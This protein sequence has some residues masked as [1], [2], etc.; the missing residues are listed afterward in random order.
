MNIFFTGGQRSDGKIEVP[1]SGIRLG[2]ELDNDIVIEGEG[3]S[4]HH[5]RIL[6][7]VEAWVVEDLGSTNGTKLN[8]IKLEPNKPTPIKDGDSIAIGRQIMVFAEKEPA[9]APPQASN[10]GSANP[11][12]TSD[13]NPQNDNKTDESTQSPP[14]PLI[15]ITPPDPSGVTVP[16]MAP[17]DS[18][19]KSE[20]ESSNSFSD[21]FSQQPE[22]KNDASLPVDD[23]FGKTK[24]DMPSEDKTDKKHVGLLFYVLVLGTA[25]L[26]VAGYLYIERMKERK[27]A[28][29]PGASQAAATKK[30]APLLVRYEKEI[31]T[32]GDSENIF[33]FVLEI[34][35]GNVTIVR[36]DLRAHLKDK[37]ARKVGKEDI[38]E[39]ENT[40]RDTDFMSLEQPQKGVPTAEEDRSQR[41]IVAYG[42]DM[43]DI[44][45]D[46]APPPMAFQEV[47]SSLEDF[48]RDVL[49]IPP[50]SLTPEEM[51]QEGLNAYRKAKEL[52]DNYEAK[53]ENLNEAIRRF[54]I[55]VENLKAFS[56]TPP[57]YE[58]AYK[59]L[60]QAEKML[61]DL[62][63]QHF[64]NMNRYY[65][66][67][68]Y[69]KAKDEMLAVMGE[70]G[71]GTDAYK[72]A[73]KTLIKLEQD[74]RKK[75][76]S[77]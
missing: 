51:R 26:M 45:V 10:I 21:F 66:L 19:A 20:S 73:K 62:V 30:G 34:K 58:E 72:K 61:K 35:N 48:S 60:Q 5:A 14:T 31:A 46:N 44:M 43:N 7:V 18:S 24:Q 52:F 57:E 1:D 59:L 23:F 75:R 63:N 4:R 33:R 22:K 27:Y 50:V 15:K 16:D 67:K 36:D 17:L 47:V 11:D 2:R 37:L 71:R 54:K 64:I 6:K 32:S 65:R 69:E 55:A 68:E 38:V 9:L 28:R 56:P 12:P 42:K 8:G 74:V 25:A 29:D 41:L 3:A 53:D 77:R 39:L 40:I 70:V 49:N 76:R 13:D